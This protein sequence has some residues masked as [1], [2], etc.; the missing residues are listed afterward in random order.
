L[1]KKKTKRNLTLKWSDPE[2]YNHYEQ[3]GKE[4]LPGRI[5]V[6]TKC[7]E[8]FCPGGRGK[9]TTINHGVQEALII[10]GLQAIYVENRKSSSSTIRKIFQNTFGMHWTL[11][12]NKWSDHD[13]G[14]F[15]H[16]ESS[17]CLTKSQLDNFFIFTFVRDPVSRFYSSV[18]QAH[19][20]Q[21][22]YKYKNFTCSEIDDWIGRMSGP[23]LKCDFDQHLETQTFGLSTLIHQNAAIG[24]LQPDK[25]YMIPMDFIGKV[26]NFREDFMTLLELIEGRNGKKISIDKRR[27]IEKMLG[28]KVNTHDG[29]KEAVYQCRNE[30]YDQ[31]VR[32]IYEQDMVC[33]DYL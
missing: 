8:D 32:N 19:E 26:E 9:A 16:R 25:S 14:V 33:F 31:K 28:R 4:I 10:D 1:K 7:L 6:Q 20:H 21:N 30:Q 3:I 15:F 2:C 12:K 17:R 23:N 13:C 18:A 29:L 11:P 24:S 5:Q 22:R 27:K